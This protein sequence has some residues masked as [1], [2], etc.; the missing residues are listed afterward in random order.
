[1]SVALEKIKP[2]ALTE[3]NLLWRDEENNEVSRV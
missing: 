3:G 2:V 1:M